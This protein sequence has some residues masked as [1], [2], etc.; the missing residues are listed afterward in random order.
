MKKIKQTPTPGV[1]ICFQEDLGTIETCWQSLKRGTPLVVLQ[2]SGGRCEEWIARF[3]SL[4][5]GKHEYRKLN[6]NRNF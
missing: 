5:K 3:I 2:G 4:K 1:L 6:D